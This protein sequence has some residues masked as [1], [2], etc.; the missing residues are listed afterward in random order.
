MCDELDL[1]DDENTDQDLMD[2]LEDK[3]KLTATQVKAEVAKAQRITDPSKKSQALL[4]ALKCI[5]DIGEPV[6]LP[7][8]LDLFLNDVIQNVSAK[9]LTPVINDL[10]KLSANEDLSFNPNAVIKLNIGLRLLLISDKPDFR[11]IKKVYDTCRSQ[12][13]MKWLLPLL[14]KSGQKKALPLIK[15]YLSKRPLMKVTHYTHIRPVPTAA[16]YANAYTGNQK[17]FQQALDWYERDINDLP[18]QSFYVAWA[19]QE[20]MKPNYKI[21]DFMNYRILMAETLLDSLDKKQKAVLIKKACDEGSLSLTTFF[22][23][24]LVKAPLTDIPIYL[25]LLKHP[26]LIVKQQV[27]DI[28]KKNNK[29]DA[30]VKQTITEMKRSDQSIDR[31]FAIQILTELDP[32]Q[33]EKLLLEAIQKEQNPTLKQ[34]FTR[35]LNEDQYY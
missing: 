30:T 22:M 17:A 34:R 31:L 11:R 12:M 14:G 23:K 10:L 13:D 9:Q 16:I 26:S 21:V 1:G 28:L 3:P 20:G 6:L 19:I 5:L 18:I 29:I 33:K 8:K 2:M 15:P 4:K 35:I 25:Q 27:Y 24:S 7:R 32:P